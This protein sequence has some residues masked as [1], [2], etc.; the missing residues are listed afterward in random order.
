MSVNLS[1]R[2]LALSGPILAK[3]ACH[4]R[5]HFRAASIAW[6]IGLLMIGSLAG[7]VVLSSSFFTPI[8]H[9]GRWVEP[10]TGDAANDVTRNS[11]VVGEPRTSPTSSAG[12]I[13]RAQQQLNLI[14]SS[15]EFADAHFGLG[16]ESQNW[17]IA[18]AVEFDA[19][20]FIRSAGLHTDTRAL[21]TQA[22]TGATLTSPASSVVDLRFVGGGSPG[23]PGFAGGGFASAG[24]GSGGGIG[25]GMGGVRGATLSDQGSSPDIRALRGPA[26]NAAADHAVENAPGQSDTAHTTSLSSNGIDAARLGTPQTTHPSSG[27]QSLVGTAA[28][29][30]PEPATLLLMGAGLC[31]LGFTQRRRR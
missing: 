6:A 27:V 12:T 31:G 13:E 20:A 16:S 8:P 21:P 4:M 25:Q 11:S 18:R 24:G 19:D 23:A 14:A 29:S 15:S 26:G 17:V 5:L 2:V 30:V 3:L 1:R 9:R 7:A 22:D 10:P 28:V